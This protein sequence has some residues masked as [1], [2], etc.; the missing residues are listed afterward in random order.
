MRRANARVVIGVALL[1]R[2]LVDAHPG[3]AQGDADARAAEAVI[4]RQLEAF[5]NGDFDTAYTFAA[6]SIQQTF[7]RL[8]F[9]RMV[10]TGYPEIAHSAFALVSKNEQASDGRRY[11]TVRILGVNGRRIEALYEMV[12]EDGAWKISGVVTKPDTGFVSRRQG[13]AAPLGAYRAS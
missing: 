3:A 4:L 5:R 13:S 7:D 11:V 9:E 8:A 2:A 6:A 12:R 10:T 1:V